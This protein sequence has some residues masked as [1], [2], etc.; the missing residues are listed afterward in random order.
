MKDIAREDAG[1][2]DAAYGHDDNP[3]VDAIFHN[4][5]DELIGHGMDHFLEDMGHYACHYA[6]D[7]GKDDY[8]DEL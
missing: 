1:D 2:Q 6:C 7:G 3:P 4:M 5:R 8:K